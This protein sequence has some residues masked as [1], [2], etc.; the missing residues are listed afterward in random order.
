MSEVISVRLRKDTIEKLDELEILLGI[1][2]NLLIEYLIIDYYLK[3][4]A[5]LIRSIHRS[6]SEGVG[7]L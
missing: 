2:K 4:K 5:K 3:L 7:E 1:N 6:T